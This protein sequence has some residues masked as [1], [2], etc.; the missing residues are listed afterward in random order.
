MPLPA[1]WLPLLWQFFLYPGVRRSSM[2]LVWMCLTGCVALP[3]SAQG[4]SLNL[5]WTSWRMN[6]IRFYE[7]K[8]KHT[9][10]QWG[11]KV[12]DHYIYCLCS[13][14]IDIKDEIPNTCADSCLC[15]CM[16][17][18][19]RFGSAVCPVPLSEGNNTSPSL[20]LAASST[21]RCWRFKGKRLMLNSTSNFMLLTNFWRSLQTQTQRRNPQ[22]SKTAHFR[23]A[24]LR[25]TCAI[26]ILSASWYARWNRPFVCKSLRS[27]S[28]KMKNVAKTKVLCL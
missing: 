22:Y 17:A 25:H 28:W 10:I 24:S 21:A 6:T 12:W 23:E 13:Y 14:L 11:S 8:K 3:P 20:C 18:D 2:V 19:L 4:C 16:C 9:H 27:L 7:K 15:M 26:I 5:C 1:L